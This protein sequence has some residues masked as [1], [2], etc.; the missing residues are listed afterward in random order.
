MASETLNLNLNF[1]NFKSI[2]LQKVIFSYID[3]KDVFEDTYRK[4]LARRLVQHTSDDAEASMISQLKARI[5]F[6]LVDKEVFSLIYGEKYVKKD[7]QCLWLSFSNWLTEF[8]Q[9]LFSLDCYR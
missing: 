3:D 1:H 4:L 7:H 8:I 9:P 5:K 2:T 6:F